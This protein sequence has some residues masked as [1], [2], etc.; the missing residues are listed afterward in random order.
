MAKGSGEKE[1]KTHETRDLW[2]NRA[3]NGDRAREVLRRILG[4]RSV[5]AG[6]PVT[7]YVVTRDLFVES[8]GSGDKVQATLGD[9]LPEPLGVEPE[10]PK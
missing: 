8:Y 9:I 3:G 2:H 6:P 1:P 5:N 10:Y 4:A 7:R